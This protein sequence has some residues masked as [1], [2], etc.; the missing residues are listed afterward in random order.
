[1]LH[2]E[3]KGMKRT[4]TCKQIFALMHLIPGR[5]LKVKTFFLSSNRSHIVYQMN[6]KVSHAH[7]IVIYTMGGL[8]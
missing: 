4:M 6:K 2:I 1:M 8:G 5:S 3:L 7:T